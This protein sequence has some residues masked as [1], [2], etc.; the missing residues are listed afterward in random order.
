MKLSIVK[1]IGYSKLIKRIPPC[2]KNLITFI[3]NDYSIYDLVIF[4]ND[5]VILSRNVN[6]AI[7]KI[8]NPNDNKKI[9]IGYCFTIESKIALN[10]KGIQFLELHEFY[11]TDE[12]YT[13][14][15]LKL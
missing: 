2:Y 10:Q 14:V 4:P 11:W 1:N 6:K 12:S 7:G 15:L 13:N 9:V 8:D 3:S 5:K